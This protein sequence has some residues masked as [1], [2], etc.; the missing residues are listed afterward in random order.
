MHTVT[1]EDANLIWRL[2]ISSTEELRVLRGLAV[3]PGILDSVSR[4]LIM[5]VNR[6]QRG[7]LMSSWSQWAYAH[8]AKS[9]FLVLYW[10]PCPFSF[11]MFEMVMEGINRTKCQEK[12]KQ[13]AYYI[14]RPFRSGRWVLK[15]GFIGMQTL[16]LSHIHKDSLPMKKRE[17]RTLL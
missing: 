14:C 1:W 2:W 16:L 7:H 4:T 11:C 9:I 12:S 17:K 6:W 15:Q 3:L 5:C 8:S 10:I 13:D